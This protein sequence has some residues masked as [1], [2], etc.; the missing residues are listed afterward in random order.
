MKWLLNCIIAELY[1]RESF[2]E[3]YY[4]EV[5][6]IIVKCMLQNIYRDLSDSPPWENREDFLLNGLPA[7]LGR[8]IGNLL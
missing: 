4:E 6:N 5:D 3:S 2:L 1:K 8:R 7:K